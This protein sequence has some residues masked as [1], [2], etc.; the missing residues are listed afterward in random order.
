MDRLT[1]WVKQILHFLT[2]ASIRL[3]DSSISAASIIGLVLVLIGCWWGARLF[4]SAITQLL[5][6]RIATP[7]AYSAG[8]AIGRLAR[9]IVWIIGSFIGLQLIGFDLSSLALIGGALGI[10]IGFGLQSVV[11]NFVSGIILLLERSLKVGDFVDLASGV[12]GT[13]TEISVRFTRVTTNAELDVIVPNSE[14]TNARV[15]N[16]TL[17]NRIRRLNV[18]FSVAYGS[19]KNLVREAA[20]AAAEKVS[21][22]VTDERRKTSVWFT[23]FGDS[24]LEFELAVWIGPG[25]VNRPGSTL[26]EY[27]WALDDTL[28][29][30]SIE[31]PFPQRDLHVR[32]GTLQVAVERSTR[33][34]ST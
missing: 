32:S 12:R 14:L 2:T 23:K 27:L 6:H 20:L 25:A 17:D 19:D 30:R 34:A 1:E 29:E 10:G 13:V 3:G 4:E 26:S 24:A 8:Y 15:T 28:R 11:A 7:G 5:R 9:Y 21:H 22:T 16:W 31:I 18:P 33:T